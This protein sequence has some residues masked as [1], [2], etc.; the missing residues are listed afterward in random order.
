MADSS[1]LKP[2]AA[3]IM[4]HVDEKDHLAVYAKLDHENHT[5]FIGGYTANIIKMGGR[6]GGQMRPMTAKYPRVY[7]EE[8]YTIATDSQIVAWQSMPNL[9]TIDLIQA[10]GFP[11]Y[12][13]KE[14]KAEKQ[15]DENYVEF[16][17]DVPRINK[18]T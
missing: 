8:M 2:V 13:I 3:W 7:E 10:K 17:F 4:S 12:R 11:D 1:M 9:R 5:V 6:I 15:N 18:T 16:V 14:V